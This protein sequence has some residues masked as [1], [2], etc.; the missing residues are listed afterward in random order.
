MSQNSREPLEILN[1]VA[2]RLRDPVSGRSLAAAGMIRQARVDGDTLRFEILVAAEHD[3][4]SRKRLP[5]LFERNLRAGGWGGPVVC[6]LV[7]DE[8]GVPAEEPAA[9]DPAASHGSDLPPQGRIEGVRHIV[10]VASGKGGVG[11]STV[12]VHL[13]LGLS[14]LG[15]QV[16]LLDADIYG[17][18]LPM[19]LGVQELP[20][21]DEN[22]HLVPVMAHGLKCMSIGF[23]LEEGKPVIWRGPMIMGV[24]KQFLQEVAWAPLDVLVIDLPPGTGDAQLTL[25]QSVA[26]SG[27][28]IVTTPQDLALLDAERGLA[29]F[30][31]LNVPILGIVENMAWYDLPGGG[32]D[33]PFGQGGAERLARRSAVDTVVGLPLDG[34]IRASGDAGR[35]EDVVGSAATAFE[36]LA[37]IVAA[38][39]AGS[40]A[41]R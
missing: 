36:S 15:L 2:G 4:A 33:H 30:R 32:Q 41:G 23:M 31:Q 39:L 21:V 40:T 19:L 1:A 9:S 35:P 14:K 20:S 8:A 16:G 17:P 7:E 26:L 6:T 18:S 28:V 13:A 29:M 5:A 22:R 3:E 24:M 37:R 34:R 10:A 38:S 12:A 11:K 25:V 27:A